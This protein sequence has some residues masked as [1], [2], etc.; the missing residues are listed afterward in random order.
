[1]TVVGPVVAESKAVVRENYDV[2][3][4]DTVYV[5]VKHVYREKGKSKGAVLMVH[6]GWH[7]NSFYDLDDN[8]KYSLQ[9]YLAKNKFDTYALDLRGCGKSYKSDYVWYSQIRIEDFAA[10]IHAVIEDIHAK[11]YEDIYVIGHSIGAVSSIFYAA[12]YAETD[13]L[14]GLVLLGTPF[15][16]LAI[17]PELEAQFRQAAENYPVIPC[18]PALIEPFFFAE[19]MVKDKVLEHTSEIILQEVIGSTVLL[20]VLDFE[21][22]E[23]AAEIN[24]ELPVL[25]IQ[26]GLDA[27]ITTQ[28]A[29]N[30]YLALGCGEND[31][32]QVYGGH[33]HDI[34]LEKNSKKVYSDIKDFLKSI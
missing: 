34:L 16:E 7:T 21:V 26:A 33:G 9:E 23:K 19:G 32:L 17:D 8:S 5:N 2:S 6:G 3:V 12:E 20:Q 29:M 25:I 4:D 14:D 27:L 10:D 11:G 24:A 1:M 13:E 30:L 15:S 31:D 22:T 28:D 18:D